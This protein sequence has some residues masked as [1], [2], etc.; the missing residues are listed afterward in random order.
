MKNK[1]GLIHKQAK[2]KRAMVAAKKSEDNLKAEELAAKYRATGTGAVTGVELAIAYD[3]DS[4][5]CIDFF[6][7]PENAFLSNK[8]AI[9]RCCCYL[10]I[11]LMLLLKDERA[12]RQD[13]SFRDEQTKSQLEE[14]TIKRD[15]DVGNLQ[16]LLAEKECFLGATK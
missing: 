1:A 14:M 4:N 9:F 3:A 5:G 10:C 16:K 12:W 2:E 11:F 7:M 13:S 8:C 15:E 6:L